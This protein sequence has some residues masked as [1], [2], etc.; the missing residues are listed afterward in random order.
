MKHRN[1]WFKILLNKILPR[2]GW[3]VTTRVDELDHNKVYGYNLDKY[4]EVFRKSPNPYC[5]GQVWVK[6]RFR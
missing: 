1:P 6:I 3:I 4:P 5:R 2:F